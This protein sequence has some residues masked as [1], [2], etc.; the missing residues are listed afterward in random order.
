MSGLVQAARTGNW[1]P[2][3][4]TAA[5]APGSHWAENARCSGQDIDTFVPWLDGPRQDPQHVR[6]KIGISLTRA[7]N[8]CAECPLAVA[9]R[10]LVDGLKHD[11]EYGIRAGLLASERVEL[12][13]QWHKRIDREAV[14]AALRGATALL[15]DAERREVIGRFACDPAVDAA[16]VAR[17]LGVS[18]KHLTKLASRYRLSLVSAAD[19]ENSSAAA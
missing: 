13:E 12:Q 16:A 15:T 10:C 17:A 19:S 4:S 7:L 9:A 8:I 6:D 18:H 2:L 5:K 11:D 14:A 3:L 1:R